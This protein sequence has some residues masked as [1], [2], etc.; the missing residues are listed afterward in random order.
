[1]RIT[2]NLS[3]ELKLA[4][5]KKGIRECDV[6]PDT[7]LLYYVIDEQGVLRLYDLGSHAQMFG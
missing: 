3:D 6:K 4:G 7:L 1:M 5:N 2:I